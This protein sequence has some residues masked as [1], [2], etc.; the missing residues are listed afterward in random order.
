M[1]DQIKGTSGK[2]L[3]AAL[4]GTTAGIIA[5]LLMAPQTGASFRKGLGQSALKVKK[6]V[7][8]AF[9]E[10]ID[11]KRSPKTKSAKARRA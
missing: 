3:M 1:L 7:Q 5:G 9:N 2:I 10:N 6:R 4:A 11:S 8:N